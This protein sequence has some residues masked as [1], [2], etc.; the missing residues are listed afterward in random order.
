M[1]GEDP[2]ER[3]QQFDKFSKLSLCLTDSGWIRFMIGYDREQPE[4]FFLGD[5]V[6]TDLLSG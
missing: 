1:W 4:R 6:H 2:L 3:N 5:C